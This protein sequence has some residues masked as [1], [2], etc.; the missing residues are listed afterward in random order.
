[1]LTAVLSIG[2][3]GLLVYAAL[4][5]LA[6]RTVPNWLPLTLLAL[7][8]CARLADH[9]LFTGLAVAGGAF[10]VL[11]IVWLLGAMG[12]GDVK[13]WAATALLIPPLLQP[14]LAFFLRVVV[15]GGI[16]AL[17]YLSLGFVVH[18]PQGLK[19]GGLLRRLLRAEAWRISRRASLPYAC[20]I[21]GSAI[22]T[23]LPLS[24]Q[25]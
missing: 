12:G 1:M 8:F 11:F 4:H 24:F 14:E 23:L 5:D 6:A 7:G 9:T 20:A 25:R 15:F 16:L 18:K 2:A 19:T 21:A 13:L 22:V 3:A 10:F 17:F